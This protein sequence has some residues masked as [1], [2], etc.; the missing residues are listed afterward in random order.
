MSVIVSRIIGD[1]FDLD[2]GAE[3]PRAV[4]LT[5]GK[6]EL[7]VEVSEDFTQ[8]AIYL[9]SESLPAKADTQEPTYEEPEQNGEDDDIDD[10]SSLPINDEY[11][12]E[13]E[14]DSI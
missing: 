6:E 10:Y 5:N 8:A 4:I 2:S 7:M 3:I 1:T 12:D 14:V 11:T 13:L 9:W